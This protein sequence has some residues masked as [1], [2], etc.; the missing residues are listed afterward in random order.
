MFSYFFNARL[1]NRHH[2]VETSWLP[3]FSTQNRLYVDDLTLTAITA[4]NYIFPT[5]ELMHHA[6][7]RHFY[8]EKN[9]FS[10]SLS[11]MQTH[12]HT[13]TH[14]HYTNL[15]TSSQDPSAEEHKWENWSLCVVP[16]HGTTYVFQTMIN[17]SFLG[18]QF[19]FF[20][21]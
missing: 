9:V 7:L 21:F 17:T 14:T 4:R 6:K 13:H 11:H 2:L 8:P 1:Y 19:F 15:Q 16:N 12:T 18:S 20:G 3:V 5:I 10:L